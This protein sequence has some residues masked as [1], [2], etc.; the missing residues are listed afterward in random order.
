MTKIAFGILVRDF[1]V[2]LIYSCSLIGNIPSVTQFIWWESLPLAVW[3]PPLLVVPQRVSMFM[4][5]R[6]PRNTS[7]SLRFSSNLMHPGSLEL[8]VGQSW[9]C[10][11]STPATIPSC[12]HHTDD[13][14]ACW[15]PGST[16]LDRPV[17]PLG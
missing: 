4:K 10:I 14:K 2:A 17:Q 12:S 11:C 15:E 5:L 9:P 8:L 3:Q 7:Y 6:S 1:S 13:G 16:L